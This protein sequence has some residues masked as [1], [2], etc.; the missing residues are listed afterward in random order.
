MASKKRA[1][2]A[3]ATAGWPS[4]QAA[5]I[6]TLVPEI[7]SD[8]KWRPTV[9]AQPPFAVMP[10]AAPVLAVWHFGVPFQDMDGLH[11]WLRQN[12]TALA[13]NLKSIMDGRTQPDA[14][15]VYYLGTYL[16]IDAGRPMY[17]TCWGY[18]SEQ[19]LETESA[20]TVG[21]PA[22]VRDLVVQ[23]R[24]FWVKDPGRSEARY[25]LAANYANLGSMPDNPFM[26][27]V[28]IDAASQP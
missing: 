28:T 4:H 9:G 27:Q 12:E 25:G 20:W 15:K 5:H 3:E 2:S 14:P 1:R 7:R 18:S 16:N 6:G 19:A 23:L 8:V 24:A 22:G 17:Q 13:G 11:G 26:L 21:I 10:A